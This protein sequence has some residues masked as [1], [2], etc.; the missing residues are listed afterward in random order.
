MKNLVNG[1]AQE[2]NESADCVATAKALGAQ[3]AELSES[4]DRAVGALRQLAAVELIVLNGEREG[5]TRDR[6]TGAWMVKTAR[7][8][9]V[10]IGTEKGRGLTRELYEALEAT[11]AELASLHGMFGDES[12]SDAHSNALRLGRAVLARANLEKDATR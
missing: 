8:A 3:V 11:V 12:N 10:S 1:K 9:L 2:V 7:K 5:G 6:A 4:L